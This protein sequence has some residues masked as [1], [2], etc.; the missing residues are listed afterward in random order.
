MSPFFLR[1]AQVL[2]RTL[3]DKPSLRFSTDFWAQ[4]WVSSTV[5]DI[6]LDPEEE[7]GSRNPQRIERE[8]TALCASFE[9][10]G[11]GPGDLLLDLGCGPGLYS[12]RFL[13]AGFRVEGWDI[14]PAAIRYARKSLGRM[15]SRAGHGGRSA[16]FHQR[17]FSR[18]PLPPASGAA[19]I[20]GIFGNL[21]EDERDR[22]LSSLARALPS[23]AAFIFDC[24]TE[25]YARESIMPRDWYTREGD[26]FWR[27]GPHLV[28]EHGT[29]F[30][31][32]R[33]VV[34]SYHIVDLGFPFRGRVKTCCVRHRW[35]DRA[36]LEAI[37]SRA[38]FILESLGAGLDGSE[39]PAKW[40]GVV[41]RRI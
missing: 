40:M 22:T 30:E 21:D 6:H 5:L 29:V 4:P 9:S 1:P 20:Y 27:R 33:T 16:R 32:A 23:G 24:F 37:L 2:A 14:S 13:A 15:P 26:G 19:M 38:G 36:E 10:H 17:D 28:F 35:Y 31:E 41:A 39:D 11:A 25:A 7:E 34:N 3:A 18:A 8:A 12:A